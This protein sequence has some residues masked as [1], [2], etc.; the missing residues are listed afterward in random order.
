MFSFQEFQTS[1]TPS[2]LQA[3]TTASSPPSPR[4]SSSAW[5]WSSIARAR[6]KCRPGLADPAHLT[7]VFRRMAGVNPGTWTRLRHTTS[8]GAC[9][10]L[11]IDKCDFTTPRVT[12][13]MQWQICNWR[14]AIPK[15]QLAP[16]RPLLQRALLPL[17]FAGGRAILLGDTHRAVP[18]LF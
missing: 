17:L 5:R 8:S 14:F 4:R 15:V 10:E 16:V 1:P 3:M 9:M 13:R 7:K 11:Q 6:L 12:H 18:M 2:G